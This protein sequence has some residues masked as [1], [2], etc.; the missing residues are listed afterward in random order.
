MNYNMIEK[1]KKFHFDSD[2]VIKVGKNEQGIMKVEYPG[3]MLKKPH[4]MPFLVGYNLDEDGI[5][6][7]LTSDSSKDTPFLCCNYARRIIIIADVMLECI[8]RGLNEE[9]FYC[10]EYPEL[11][12]TDLKNFLPTPEEVKKEE[13][14]ESVF[15][16]MIAENKMNQDV[17]DGISEGYQLICEIL[18]IG[19]I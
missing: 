17:D 6:K 9:L 2:Y 19:G 12:F 10:E 15:V 7:K 14:L 1:V 13:A 18:N 4:L 5:I 11:M 3:N 8:N 16:N